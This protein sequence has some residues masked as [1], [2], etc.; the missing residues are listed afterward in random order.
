MIQLYNTAS[1]R[2]ETYESLDPAKT[3]IYT[4]GPTVYSEPLIGN[5]VAYLRWDLLVRTLRANDVAVR[6]VMNI[7]DVGHLVS[8]A[9]EGEDKMEKGAKREGTTAWEVAE[10]YT[11]RFLEGMTVLNLLPP[12]VMPKATEHIDA[13]I[14]LIQRLEAG[15]HT[16]VIDDGVYFD[17]STFARY[18]DFAHLD[19]EALKAGARVAV[20]TQKRHPTD[21]AL[22][23]FSPTGE[24]RDMEWESPWGKGFPG[25][26]IECSAMALAYLG[27]TIDIHTGGIDHIPVHHTN[28][29]AQSE[30]ATGKPFA[31][32]W[33]HA[34][35]L[36]IEGAKVSKSLNNGYS[37]SDLTD[38]GYD[39]MAFRMFVLQSHYRSESNFTWDNLSAA[40]A[41]YQH[42]R[43]VACLRHQT[44]DTLVSDEDKD[45]SANGSVLAAKHAAL[46]ALNND[47]NS[48]L[49]LTHI[50]KAFD[51]VEHAQ[52]EHVQKTS[53]TALIEFIDDT[54]GLNLG[55]STPDIDDNTK[56]LLLERLRAR[57]E[58][59]WQRSDE[60]RDQLHDRGVGVNDTAHGSRWYYL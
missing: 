22:W 19:L 58:K 33:L 5:W 40:A 34:N 20:N 57:E 23:K 38:K 17:T 11:N 1:G 39:P 46:E 53:L 16:Y 31:R 25:W 30:A 32:F 37:L 48:P 50:E 56:Q 42:W 59:Q 24:K 41:R 13:Q 21:F 54:L 9:D 47:L 10:R 49:A 18:A 55:G 51:A 45:S 12:E 28:E 43:A 14:E 2:V 27:E 6:R 44:N 15:N 52:P 7:T 29:I 35:F 26:H 4:C 3:T 60:L 36:L 8:D